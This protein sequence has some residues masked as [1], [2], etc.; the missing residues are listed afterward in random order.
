[1]SARVCIN[2]TRFVT[3]VSEALGEA[4]HR[5]LEMYSRINLTRKLFFSFLYFY[6]DG[7]DS[8]CIIKHQTFETVHVL[9]I[10]IR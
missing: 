5:V 7:H 1:M 10:L 9:P 6:Q 8:G 4:R 2:R 3:A